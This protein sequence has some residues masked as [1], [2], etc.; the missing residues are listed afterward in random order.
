MLPEAISEVLGISLSEILDLYFR[1]TDE[2][3]RERM[4]W[5]VIDRRREDVEE[6][7]RFEEESWRIREAELAS[8]IGGDDTF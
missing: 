1:D 6:R 2:V 5:G 3:E 4:V 7:M 8:Y